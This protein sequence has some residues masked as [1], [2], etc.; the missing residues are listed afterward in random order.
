MLRADGNREAVLAEGG[1]LSS[2]RILSPTST[3]I[4]VLFAL[5]GALKGSPIPANSFLRLGDAENICVRD[6]AAEGH[7]NNLRTTY[8]IAWSCVVTIF[9]CVWS[10]GHPN[11]PGPRD[12]GWTRLKRRAMTML[13]ALIS[14]EVM[15]M[16]AIRQHVAAKKIAREYNEK[17]AKVV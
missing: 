2:H 7:V 1:A 5:L 15:A 12:A 11:I 16:W 14:P 4:L 3:L 17:V 9:A 10:S 8:G 6:T 13:S